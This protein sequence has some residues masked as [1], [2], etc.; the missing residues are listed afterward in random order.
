MDFPLVIPRMSECSF[1]V[2][3]FLS[4]LLNIHGEFVFMW[5]VRKNGKTTLVGLHVDVTS[6]N[7]ICSE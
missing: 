1:L 6:K 2:E 7:R 3:K 5:L 4:M